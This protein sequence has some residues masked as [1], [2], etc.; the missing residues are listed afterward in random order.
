MALHDTRDVREAVGVFHD[1]DSLR[2]AVDD[3]LA[4]GFEQGDLTLLATEDAVATKLARWFTRS[5]QSPD[6]DASP[7]RIAVV[8]KQLAHGGP[9]LCVSLRDADRERRAA[10]ILSRRSAE[11]VYVRELPVEAA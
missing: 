5:E 4:S 6:D 8:E 3:L 9:L 11:D 1:A 2:K 7:T 10:E